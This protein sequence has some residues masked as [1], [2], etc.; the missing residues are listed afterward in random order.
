MEAAF[1]KE[2]K[3]RRKAQAEVNEQNERIGELEKQEVKLNKWESRKPTIN[4]YLGAVGDMTKYALC[5]LSS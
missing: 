2:R 1:S 3:Q 5:S 4:H